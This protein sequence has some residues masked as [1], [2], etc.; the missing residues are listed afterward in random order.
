MAESKA[1]FQLGGEA[2]ETAVARD[3][4]GFAV[5]LG[6]RSVRARVRRL[7][8]GALAIALG[9]GRVI[10]AAVT[11]QGDKR[12]VTVGGAT[13]VLERQTGRRRQADTHAGGLESP[14]PGRVLAVDVDPGDVV[15]AGQTLL[16]IEAMK[17][18][19]P[20][21]APRAGVVSAIRCKAGDMVQPGVALVELG[22]VPA[23]PIPNEGAP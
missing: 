13:V 10:R 9:D 8:A 17:M 19:H 2:T 11:R 16:L 1:T 15:H 21:K 5:R 18:E 7:G 20:I 3:G 4:D 12:W 14:L 23:A 22:P 6:D